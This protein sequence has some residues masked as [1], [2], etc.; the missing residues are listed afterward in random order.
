MKIVKG[1]IWSFWEQ[2]YYIVIPT[3]GFVKKNGEAVMGRGLALQTKERFPEF[4]RVLGE[5]LKVYGNMVFVFADYKLITFPVKRVWLEKASLNL[6]EESCNALSAIFRYNLCSLRTPVY[7]PKVGCGNGG[8]N[9]ED[10]KPILEK[11]LD[12]RFIL[13]EV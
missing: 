2:G 7:L 9:W 1:D 5:R 3:N 12:D 10:V 8:L 11:A 6:I 13:C 4:P